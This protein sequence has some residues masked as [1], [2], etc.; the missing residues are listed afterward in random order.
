MK[1]EVLQIYNLTLPAHLDLA[2]DKFVFMCLTG[3]RLSDATRVSP[4][5][6]QGD[7]IKGLLNWKTRNGKTIPVDVPLN[8]IAKQI[9]DK[10]AVKGNDLLFP[11]IPDPKF[12]EKIKTICQMVD[13]LKETVVYYHFK[14]GKTEQENVPRWTLVS[15]H[16][17]RRT[18]ASV[19]EKEGIP[20]TFTMMITGHAT[21][22]SYYK[23]VRGS[24]TQKEVKMAADK[25]NEI[26]G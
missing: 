12:N 3:L 22:E 10:Y 9:W 17:G 8:K 21:L 4:S 6:R 13:S 11:F 19:N 5:H 18:F 2:R 7:Y 24:G 25:L 1:E 23:Y 14:I 26:Y 20:S 15:A 16:T